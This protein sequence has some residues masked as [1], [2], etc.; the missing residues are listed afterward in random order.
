MS[1]QLHSF[2]LGD[3]APH[4]QLVLDQYSNDLRDM[5]RVENVGDAHD[6][7][8][9]ENERRM[10]QGRIHDVGEAQEAA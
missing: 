1:E 8:L 7:A 4:E 3:N 2:N 6:M 5:A 10:N 9:V